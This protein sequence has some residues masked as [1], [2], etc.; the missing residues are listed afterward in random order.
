MR[1]ARVEPKRRR[2]PEEELGARG[3]QDEFSNNYISKIF[4]KVNGITI[5]V[6]GQA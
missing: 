1:G 6:C 2:E 5:R 3:E 4:E